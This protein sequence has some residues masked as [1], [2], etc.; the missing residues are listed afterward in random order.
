MRRIRGFAI[1][2]GVVCFAVLGI[3]TGA[4]AQ[5]PAFVTS[6]AQLA[7]L[8][9]AGY[10]AAV[11]LYFSAPGDADPLTYFWGPA[12]C[13]IPG[14]D[15]GSEV[16]GTTSAGG[17]WNAHFPV[18]GA[19]VREWGP[20][21]ALANITHALTW[22]SGNYAG[23]TGTG[24]L[25]FPA[26]AFALPGPLTATLQPSTNIPNP[27]MTIAGMGADVTTLIFPGGSNGIEVGLQGLTSTF[28]LR[29]LTLATLGSPS[30]P[31]S[32]LHLAQKNNS[33][34]SAGESAQSDVS[35]VTFRGQDGYRASDGW[36]NDVAVNGVSNINFI[37]DDFV[38]PAVAAGT[39]ILLCG[40]GACT[41]KGANGVVGVV[42][43]ISQS[44]FQGLQY[45][46]NYNQYSQG[47]TV[48]G[49]T[50]LLENGYGIYVPGGLDGEAKPTQLTLAD[51]Q[52]GSNRYC[53]FDGSGV[54]GELISNNLIFTNIPFVSAG[55]GV[56]T[57][58]NDCNITGNDFAVSLPTLESDPGG[59]GVDIV[60]GTGGIVTGNTFAYF[61]I[62]DGGK[63]S[64]AGVVLEAPATGVRVSANNY[65]N[66]HTNLTSASGGNIVTAAPVSG[67]L[68]AVTGAANNGSG[69]VRLAVTSTASFV[70]GEVVTVAGV[71]GINAVS[72]AVTA[73]MTVIDGTHM[74]LN[75]VAFSGTYTGGGMVSA[76]P[77]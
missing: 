29:D 34:P 28:H 22:A 23:A 33:I 17:C 67:A 8:A 73:P 42:Y 56:Q 31:A 48:T 9:P 26:G 5:A 32:G 21:G 50:N 27:S 59:I 18:T 58:C 52:C 13:L 11:R 16:P 10:T 49:G 7:S 60:G 65:S 69:F 53:V 45:G 14:G 75:S 71:G 6:N 38:G 35:G 20:I 43:N 24:R 47:L 57:V 63:G 74:D 76:P 77:P 30:L 25:V 66:N 19:D 70:S 15:Q 2:A 46:I 36:T 41:P 54:F 3:A 72:A 39:G 55:V 61:Y 44:T 1:M 68:T 40:G 12:S 4:R 62:H 64:Q 51:S 37:N